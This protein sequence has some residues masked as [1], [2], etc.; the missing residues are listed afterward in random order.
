MES[1]HKAL[2][3]NDEWMGSFIANV[4]SCMQHIPRYAVLPEI[5]RV[6]FNPPRTIINWA[7]KTKTIV[8]CRNGDI[9]DYE[10]GIALCFMKK[11][12][13]NGGRYNNIFHEWIPKQTESIEDVVAS[14]Y[15]DGEHV[16]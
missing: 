7:D 9:F 13:G 15:Q 12:M 4:K 3:L 10:K 8:V 5:Q 11:V 2:N 6:I 16:S 14:W 1:T